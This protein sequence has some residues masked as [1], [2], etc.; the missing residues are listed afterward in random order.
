MY[1]FDSMGRIKVD[2]I[3]LLLQ[4]QVVSYILQNGKYINWS[5]LKIEPQKFYE[6]V[7]DFKRNLTG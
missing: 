6:G 1:N 7:Q 5:Y 3:S 2:D 4:Y